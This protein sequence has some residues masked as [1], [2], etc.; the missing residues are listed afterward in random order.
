[1]I[2][3]EGIA[4]LEDTFRGKDADAPADEGNVTSLDCQRTEEAT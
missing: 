3:R 2:T 1:M 4:L